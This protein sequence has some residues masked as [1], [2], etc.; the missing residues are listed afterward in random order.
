MVQL[1]QPTRVEGYE[2]IRLRSASAHLD[3]TFVPRAGMVGASLRDGAEELLG[4]WASRCCTR[5][6]TASPP[7]STASTAPRCGCRTTRASSRATST[8]AD[9]RPA[10][11]LPALAAA[12]RGRRR[13]RRLGAPGQR[14]TATFSITVER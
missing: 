1:T 2:A 12:P 11:R 13:H 3:A 8:A 4:G 9:P 5:G 7:T 10:R 6:P 14:Y